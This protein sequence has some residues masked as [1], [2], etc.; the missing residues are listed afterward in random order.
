MKAIN[1][2]NKRTIYSMLCSLMLVIFT[3]LTI[4]N[5]SIVEH[6]TR[7]KEKSE[8]YIEWIIAVLREPMIIC[9]CNPV[10]KSIP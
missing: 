3:T 4:I 5:S 1:Y 10:P 6:Y 2:F 8:L 9:A 7:E